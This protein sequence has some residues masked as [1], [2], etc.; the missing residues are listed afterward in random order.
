MAL[1]LVKAWM[2]ISAPPISKSLSN[3]RGFSLIEVLVALVLVS[4]VFLTIPSSDTTSK[5]RSLKSAID[6]IDRSIRFASNESVLRNTVVRLGIDLDKTPVEYSVEYGPPG[7]MP[8]PDMPEK[9][10]MSLAEEKAD[11]EK[12][13]KLD[14]QFTKVEEFAE[15]K[16]EINQDVTIQALG[17]TSMKRLVTDGIAYVYFYPT[18]EKDGAI[19]FFS[20]DEE[21]GML[22]VQPFLAETNSTFETVDIGKG[23]DVVQNRVNEVYKE[24][25]GK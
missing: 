17:S 24:W 13:A 16:H 2:Q 25:I 1:S 22:E 8:L 5:H 20:T 23:D 9:T 4:L 3:Q 18:G 10:V 7:N 21:L 12:L 19:L 15:I 14:K 11:K 6:D